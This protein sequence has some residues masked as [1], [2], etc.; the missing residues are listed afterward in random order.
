MD[1]RTVGVWAG[2]VG[3]PV[4]AVV[5]LA[6]D[7]FRADFDPMRRFISE[8]AIGPL[9]WIQDANFLLLGGLVV[10]FAL[11][12]AA[13]F[14]RERPARIGARLLMVIGA[15]IFA[16]GFLVADP[17]ATAP[18]ELSWHGLMHNLVG[19]LV[20]F[21]LMPVSCYLFLRA[22]SANNRWAGLRVWTS[23]AVLVTASFWLILV[24][25]PFI[26]VFVVVFRDWLAIDNWI[27]LLNRLVVAVW[28][29]WL[30][31]FAT[32]MRRH[33]NDDGPQEL[34]PARK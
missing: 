21:S 15:G 32:G 22:F 20:V 19:G 29:L 13:E 30:L 1:R 28:L 4:F 3:P 33:V 11:T 6:Q 27:G 31:V 16:S 25:G 10:T 12:T 8:L 34:V 24:P 18:D 7:A 26:P 5:V 14:S 2:L 17:Y 9:G 23:I